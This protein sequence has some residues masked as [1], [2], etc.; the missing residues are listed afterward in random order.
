MLRKLWVFRSGMPA[1]IFP[2]FR[3]NKGE[4][5][6]WYFV[7][8]RK[9]A[10]KASVNSRSSWEHLIIGGKIEGLV[11]LVGIA[12][13]G[14]VFSLDTE[15]SGKNYAVYFASSPEVFTKEI[16]IFQKFCGN[17]PQDGN[18]RSIKTIC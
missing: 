14:A 1:E 17:R 3:L 7:W 6:N 10:I 5:M 11:N 4:V 9:T 2:A 16:E 15:E 18:R 8:L 12:E 13:N